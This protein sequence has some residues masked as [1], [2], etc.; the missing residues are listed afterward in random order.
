MQISQVMACKKLK[1]IDVTPSWRNVYTAALQEKKHP[2]PKVT[3]LW[4]STPQPNVF[5]RHGPYGF[6]VSGSS[7]ALGLRSSGCNLSPYLCGCPPRDQSNWKNYKSYT[8]K[9]PW[10]E[11]LLLQTLLLIFLD[12]CLFVYSRASP[13][14]KCFE[15]LVRLV[16]GCLHLF[17][18]APRRIILAVL[19]KGPKSL[20]CKGWIV[21]W[22]HYWEM[23]RLTCISK[24]SVLNS[25][26]LLTRLGLSFG[27]SFVYHGGL[28]KPLFSLAP[29]FM[30]ALRS[31]QVS[32]WMV[33]CFWLMHESG[34]N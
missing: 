3:I 4:D 11:G 15:T 23:P 7:L 22:F 5:Q 27:H 20:I 30:P 33:A 18:L 25:C 13:C 34:R 28:S 31:S 21:Q 19:P 1:R 9:N 32:A 26:P 8:I 14:K 24:L 16:V 6:P 29:R 2:R 17:Q 12:P 10:T